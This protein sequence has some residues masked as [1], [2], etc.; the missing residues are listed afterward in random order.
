MMR[1]C[2]CLQS[3]CLRSL[4]AWIKGSISRRLGSSAMEVRADSL[5]V[6]FNTENHVLIIPTSLLTLSSKPEEWLLN[7]REAKLE[8]GDPE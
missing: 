5:S 2:C 1:A 4:S 6:S 7:D 3:S 8:V